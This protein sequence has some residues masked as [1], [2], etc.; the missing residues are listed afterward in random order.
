MADALRAPRRG[1]PHE[2]NAPSPRR[3]GAT[4]LP[5]KT[6]A[7]FAAATLAVVV[8]LVLS[9]RAYEDR[10]AGARRLTQ[11]LT[12]TQQLEALRATLTG[13]ET[14]QRGFLLTASDRYLEPYN[15]AVLLVPRELEEARRLV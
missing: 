15:E 14:G 2:G 3:P 10:T 1:G 8:I 4:W 11:I 6:I 7:G 12:T 9:Y 5:V 13:A